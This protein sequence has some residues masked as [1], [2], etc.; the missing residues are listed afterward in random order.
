MTS[1][2]RSKVLSHDPSYLVL[3]GK[4]AVLDGID[5]IDAVSTVLAIFLSTLPTLRWAHVRSRLSNANR[6]E[7]QWGQNDISGVLSPVSVKNSTNGPTVLFQSPVSNK[8]QIE[9]NAY[10]PRHSPNVS[11]LTI[12]V[13]KL[14][15]FRNINLKLCRHVLHHEVLFKVWVFFIWKFKQWKCKVI[16]MVKST[17]IFVISIFVLPR[18][19][20]DSS[21][22]S[23]CFVGSQSVV[24]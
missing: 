19:Q 1:K 18:N 15:H 12:K 23:S 7:V 10:D 24:S 5:A 17:P 14:R 20:F 8:Y 21:A 9:K 6:Q 13:V 3:L 22:H 11:F 16:K 2:V 4:I